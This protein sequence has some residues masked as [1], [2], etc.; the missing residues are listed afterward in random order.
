MTKSRSG[1]VAARK[2]TNRRRPSGKV[3]SSTCAGAVARASR[4]PDNACVRVSTRSNQLPALPCNNVGPQRL[5]VL[6]REN[7]APW[8]HVLYAVSDRIDEARGLV[9]GEGLE[10]DSPLPADHAHPVAGLAPGGVELRALLDLLGRE[11]LHRGVLR[12]A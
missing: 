11:R 1:A 7:V 8:R 12:S 3:F 6:R 10:I 2:P 4:A 9:A 5:N